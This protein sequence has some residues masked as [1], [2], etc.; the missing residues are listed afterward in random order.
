MAY[1][2]GY[3]WADGSLSTSRTQY[4]VFFSSND[5]DHLET[6]AQIVGVPHHIVRQGML[7]RCYNL[8][9]ANK[10]MYEDI[11]ALG[12][13]PHK[14]STIGFPSV[15]DWFLADFLRG[16]VDGDGS[17]YLCRGRHPGLSIV[18][19]SQSFLIEL[20]ERIEAT[21]G[22][23]TPRLRRDKRKRSVWAVRWEGIRAKCLV[24]WLYEGAWLALPRKAACAAE[25]VA[26][27]P[28]RTT[29]RI[30]TPKMREVFAVYLDE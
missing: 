16:V 21:T 20:V 8:V 14:S 6:I 19:G 18:S 22:V 9:F 17:L 2:L 5:R 11:E 10:R 3:W 15:P 30:V 26:W 12:G 24:G 27:R 29:S 25:Q 28:Q 23:P 1:V 7:A 13:T 4:R